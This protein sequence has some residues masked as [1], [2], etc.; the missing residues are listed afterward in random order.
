MVVIYIAINFSECMFFVFITFNSSKI[1]YSIQLQFSSNNTFTNL[2]QNPNNH[3]QGW[4][5]AVGGGSAVKD[6]SKASVCVVRVSSRRTT[7]L[8]VILVG[9]SSFLVVVLFN[10]FEV[11][12]EE[13]CNGVLCFYNAYTEI[14]F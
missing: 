13:W 12:R 6:A 4:T 3:L 1:Q 7:I 9:F 11:V 8:P 5:D 2:H 10:A 14:S